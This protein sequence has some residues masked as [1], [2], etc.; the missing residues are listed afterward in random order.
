MKTGD[1]NR[2][3]FTYYVID[4]RSMDDGARLQSIDVEYLIPDEYLIW[5][6][7]AHNNDFLDF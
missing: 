6:L 3:I 5:N 7:N 1:A 4:D 2:S